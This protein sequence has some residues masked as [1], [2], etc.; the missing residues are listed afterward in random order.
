[1]WQVIGRPDVLIFLDVSYPV[2]QARRWMSWK[3]EDLAEQ[4]RRLAHARAHCDLYVATDG[5][6]IEAVREQVLAFL[7]QRPKAPSGRLDT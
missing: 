2:A 4:Q 6:E 7:A 5:L 3:P 1:M